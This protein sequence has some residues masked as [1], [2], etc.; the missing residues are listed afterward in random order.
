M[1]EPVV[2]LIIG[3]ILAILIWTFLHHYEKP[4]APRPRITR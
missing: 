2:T 3:I 1:K 4:Q